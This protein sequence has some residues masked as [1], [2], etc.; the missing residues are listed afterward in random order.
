MKIV[1]PSKWLRTKSSVCKL[2]DV[3]PKKPFPWREAASDIESAIQT[4]QLENYAPPEA[5]GQA[6]VAKI[7]APLEK[8]RDALADIRRD[9]PDLIPTLAARASFNGNDEIDPAKLPLMQW[10]TRDDRLNTLCQLLDQLSEIL[11]NDYTGPAFEPDEDP[12][13][14]QFFKALQ[15]VHERYM[16]KRKARTTEFVW[17]LAVESGATSAS[18]KR[19]QNIAPKKFPRRTGKV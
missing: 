17:S 3:D 8:L 13:A 4:I 14:A 12:V 18:L 7:R 16:P 2:F 11:A 6:H 19:F 9:A 5:K 15:P 10:T 1:V